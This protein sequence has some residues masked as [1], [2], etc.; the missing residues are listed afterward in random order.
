M[1]QEQCRRQRSRGPQRA[2]KLRP[3][4]GATGRSDRA[5]RLIAR[6][7]GDTLGAWGRHPLR[8]LDGQILGR[9]NHDSRPQGCRQGRALEQLFAKVR[10][11]AEAVK[12]A[13]EQVGRKLDPE[14][15]DE[16][17]NRVARDDND[18]RDADADDGADRAREGA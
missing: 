8:H 3:L 4:I 16:R 7:T 12:N 5:D 18:R 9:Q 11:V 17:E 14:I 13:S 2:R 6:L 1:T 10:V 15:A